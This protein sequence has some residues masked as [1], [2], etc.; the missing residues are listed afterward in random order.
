[1]SINPRAA[2]AVAAILLLTLATAKVLPAAGLASLGRAATS[3]SPLRLAGPARP[4]IATYP[5]DRDYTMVTSAIATSAWLIYS[6]SNGSGGSMLLAE[7]RKN[8]QISQ[9]LASPSA[10]PL[11]VRAVTDHW[12]IWTQGSGDASSA[13]SLRAS[14]LPPAAV[15]AASPLA[16]IDSARAT[17][18]TPT[19]LGGVWASGESVLVAGT[20]AG[21]YGVLLRYDLS[22][23]TP[24]ARTLAHTSS[25]GHLLTDPSVDGANTYWADV[26]YDSNVLHSAIW[27]LDSSG[28]AQQVS[29]DDGAFHPAASGGALVWVDVPLNALNG[30]APERDAD[31][32]NADVELVNEL[33]GGLR[34][35]DL[36]TGQ[37]WQISPRADVS[38]LQGG[39]SLLLWRTDSQTHL[40]DLR[41]KSPADVDQQVRT[42]TLAAASR[43][44]VVW[45]TST[46]APL[47]VYDAP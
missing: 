5:L 19:I 24:V 39:G 16:L 27:R 35:R 23:G 33:N 8:R 17:D 22:S 46:S 42:A 1:M 37:Q 26:W 32:A 38:S 6:A 29:S 43:T 28:S 18:P 20:T 45:E 21:G 40:Y 31:Q 9:L 12:V 2:L 30:I 25:P 3:L 13:W 14:P 15:S 4:T 47:D 34:A 41:A 36:A 11:T 44:S 7:S 10:V